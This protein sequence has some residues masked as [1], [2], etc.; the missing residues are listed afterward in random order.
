M[1]SK[2]LKADCELV[3]KL[4]DGI[5]ALHSYGR[6]DGWVNHLGDY[7]RSGTVLYLY[8]IYLN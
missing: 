8:G 4:V 5:V 1:M 6:Q 3:D 2:V 7:P